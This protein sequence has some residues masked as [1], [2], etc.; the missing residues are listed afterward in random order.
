MLWFDR[1]GEIGSEWIQSVEWDLEKGNS[2]VQIEHS[3]SRVLV[4][5]E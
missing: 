2:R 3:E 4:D 1:Y 5:G